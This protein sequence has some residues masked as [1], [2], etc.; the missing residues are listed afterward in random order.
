MKFKWEMVHGYRT[1]TF[2]YTL[3]EIKKILEMDTDLKIGPHYR[4]IH[5]LPDNFEIGDFYPGSEHWAMI[6]RVE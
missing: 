1:E 4:R 2:F 5:K 3:P 6:E